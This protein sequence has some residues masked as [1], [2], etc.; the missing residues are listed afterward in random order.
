MAACGGIA[1]PW[2]KRLM[3]DVMTEPARIPKDLLDRVVS[4]LKPRRIILFGPHA[5][6]EAG[7]DSDWDLLVVDDDD[8]PAERMGW[9]ALW[10]ARRGFA[11]AVDLIPLPRIRVPRPGGHRRFPALDRRDRR[12]HRL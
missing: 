3:R 6:G 8:T 7:P 2:Y 5:R 10:E 12:H 4:R 1:R 9:R 11:G